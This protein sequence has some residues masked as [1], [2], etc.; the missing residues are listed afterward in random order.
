MANTIKYN[1]VDVFSG[2]C[3]TPLIGRSFEPVLVGE[4]WTSKEV[5]TLTSTIT[6]RCLAYTDYLSLQQQLLSGFRKDFQTLDIFENNSLI[7]SLS[8]IK[9]NNIS[10][11][12]N[13]YA[14][15]Y[16]PFVIS[17]EC[18]PSGY[19][20]GTFGILE[21]RDEFS[22]Q[23]SE[24]GVVNITHTVSCRGI[25]TSNN[26]SD[27]LANAKA[28]VQARTGYSGQV[29][30]AFISTINLN[31][32]YQTV[33]ESVDR[34]NNAYEVKESYLA[35]IYSS[36]AG[37]LRYT[38]DFSSG[39]IDGISRISLK[40]EINGCKSNTIAQLRSR[41]SNFSGFNEVL[42]VFK[43]ITNRTDLNPIPKTK[44]VAEDFT[45][46]NLSFSFL[47]DDSQ[48][49]LTWFDPT[50][51]FEYNF[52]TDVISA[53]IDGVIGSIEPIE[54]RWQ[55]INDLANNID[56]YSMI[57][58]YYTEFVNRNAPHLSG[59][60]LN[61]NPISSRR[62]ESEFS[63]QIAIGAT[64]SNSNIPPFG[65]REFDYSINVVPAIKKYSANPI[66]NGEGAYDIR[67]L[68]F[69]NRAV[70]SINLQG[71]ADDTH[72]QNDALA[73]L[74]QQAFRLRG[75]YISGTQIHLNDQRVSIGNSSFS[76]AASVEAQYTSY[77]NLFNF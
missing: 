22:F 74:K 32:C 31:P 38:T 77:S 37:I 63:S 35:D 7:L 24:N 53:S 68:G 73:I 57:V 19:F 4:R 11:P 69:N 52:E 51:S 58:P 76:K 33:A 14:Y 5:I 56:L 12:E 41:Y 62:S 59:F 61:P 10:F 20:S 49:G 1:N 70:C 29:F 9:V 28:W 17:L 65:L 60:L 30:P 2:I 67:D 50:I 40:G 21:P 27:S 8:G 34:I 46:L 55:K 47:W 23:E 13:R 6:G 42:N 15:G 48:L 72:S 16:I 75:K 18:Y 26:Q 71:I 64:Y 36:G 66:L 45:N 44:T 3:P 43:K 25:Q 54:V 39:I